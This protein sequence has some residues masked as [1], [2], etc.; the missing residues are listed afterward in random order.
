MIIIIKIDT[1]EM[2]LTDGQGDGGG[3]EKKNS[4]FTL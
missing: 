4:T 3:G 1:D 2:S